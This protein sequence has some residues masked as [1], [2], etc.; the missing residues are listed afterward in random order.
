MFQNHP[1]HSSRS[2]LP[3]ITRFVSTARSIRRRAVVA[4]IVATGFVL[5]A[6]GVAAAAPRAVPGSASP[7]EF[8]SQAP[9]TGSGTA[10]VKTASRSTAGWSW[11]SSARS[12]AA[13][14]GTL[15]APL[16]AKG[17]A[18]PL[19]RGQFLAALVRVE[20]LRARQYGT[21][22]QL[23]NR[24]RPAPARIDAPAGSIGARAI[25]LRWLAPIG[26][27]AALTRPITSNEA[28]LAVAGMLGLRGDV[29][30]FAVKL[31]TEVPGVSGATTYLAAQALVRTLGLRYNVLD[32]YDELELGPNDTINVA[33]ASYMLQVSATSLRSWKL[34]EARRLA[35]TFDLPQ[36]GPNQATV[37]AT[38]VRLLGQPYVWAGETEGA[39]AEGHGGFDCSGFTIR[40]INSSGVAPSAL[41]PINERTTYTQSAVGPRIGRDALQPADA[42]FFGDRGPSSAPG[43]NYHAGV[44]MGNG[45]FIHSS[46]GNGGVAI[47][48]LDGWWKSQFSWGRRALLAP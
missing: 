28:A 43:A 39:Q 30:T 46:G 40:I 44:Y 37:L 4:T 6:G 13:R 21:T 35:T 32:P 29:Q 5:F 20:A 24:S 15:S 8:V 9:I 48:T 10:R 17:P 26:G 38:G 33:H 31:R 22:P 3:S 12:W 27:K 7:A 18:T 1:H 36:L 11:S 19:T 25:A 14:T 47:D 45:W 23:A 16:V 2:T 41:A 34:D 42:I